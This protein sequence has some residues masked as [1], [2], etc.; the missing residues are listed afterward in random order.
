MSGV[1][2]VELASGDRMPGIGLGTFGS[3]RYSAAQVGA[4]VVEAIEV[5]YR[6]I[7]CASVYDN[8]VEVGEALGA[9]IAAGADR[10]E[11]WVTSKVWND[12]H[13]RIEASCEQS[14]RDLGLDHLD[15]FL[16]H[17]PFPNHHD[18]GVDVDARDPHAVPYSHHRYMATWSQMERL[19]TRGLVRN[20]GTSNMTVSKLSAVVD[21]ATLPLAVNEM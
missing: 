16:V 1:L 20:I 21:D 2:M 14:L 3:D 5:G 8:E 10:S 4:A 18:V 13:D 7:D 12:S 17:W 6:H 19:V 11:L 15:L 9:A